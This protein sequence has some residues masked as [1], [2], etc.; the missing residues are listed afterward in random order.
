VYK[1]DTIMITEEKKYNVVAI[2]GD[3]KILLEPHITE[4]QAMIFCDNHNWEY[5]DKNKIYRME[6]E[7]ET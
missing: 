1:E 2:H 6:I 4:A 7:K 5:H 3:E